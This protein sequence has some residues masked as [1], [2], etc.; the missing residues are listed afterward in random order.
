MEMTQETFKFT[1]EELNNLE[2]LILDKENSTH[3]I[4]NNLKEYLHKELANTKKSKYELLMTK[5]IFEYLTSAIDERL[6][7]ENTDK[8]YP[9]LESLIKQE[10]KYGLATEIETDAIKPFFI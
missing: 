10:R 1:L 2:V 7:P 5:T 4:A 9:I 8:I 3:I 6:T